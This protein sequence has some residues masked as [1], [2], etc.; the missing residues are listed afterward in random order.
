MDT[1]STLASGS[2]DGKDVDLFVG[3]I[4]AETIATSVELRFGDVGPSAGPAC[5]PATELI[6]EALRLPSTAFA[7]ALFARF[8]LVLSSNADD[9]SSQIQLQVG[10]CFDPAR[11]KT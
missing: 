3:M 10:K 9:E 11:M 6:W 4:V 7:G 5:S 1:G 2:A 8:L